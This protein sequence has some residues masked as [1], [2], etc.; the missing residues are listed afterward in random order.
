MMPDDKLKDLIIATKKVSNLLLNFFD[1][2]GRIALIQ[3]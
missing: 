1:D 3:E 2:A